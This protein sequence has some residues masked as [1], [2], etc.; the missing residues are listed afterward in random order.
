M[1]QSGFN[2]DCEPR[3][4]DKRVIFAAI[5]VL[6]F[7]DSVAKIHQVNNV[8]ACLKGTHLNFHPSCL[9]SQSPSEQSR[10]MLCCL[11]ILRRLW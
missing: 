10:L 3:I 7:L 4:V 6:D 8:V 11:A 5:A 2:L 1:A 9:G